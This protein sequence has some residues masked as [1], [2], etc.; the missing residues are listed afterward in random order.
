MTRVDSARLVSRAGVRSRIVAVPLRARF[1]AVVLATFTTASLPIMA[2]PAGAATRSGTAAAPVTPGSRYLAL[3]DSV[4]FGYEEPST[5]PA[6]NYRDASS[7]VPY[8]EQ[9][10]AAMHLI[11]ANSACPGETSSGFIDPSAPSF[12]CENL[13]GLNA[14]YR[15]LFPLHVQYKGS[16]LAYALTYLRRYRNVR[17]VSLMIGA[18]D[19]FLCDQT[20]GTGC[21]GATQQAMI[22]KLTA[23]VHRIL[24]AVRARYH[25]QLAIVNYYS[26]DYAS[27]F[28]DGQA[29]ALDRA[30]DSAAKPFHVEIADGWAELK[31][32]AR[33]FGGDTCKAGLLT[34]LS[35]G[36]CGVHPSHAGQALL[37]QALEKVIRL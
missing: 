36:G 31:A 21:R 7:F 9:V 11:V 23:N 12:G 10:G 1:V 5:V 2:A 35:T 27:V 20:P 17:L 3:G 34:R 29:S 24:S 18:N 4:T 16:Q 28:V 8:P 30:L 25:G 13:P 32:A 22:S 14:G 33:R 6:P 26:I 15:T 19:T 37:A